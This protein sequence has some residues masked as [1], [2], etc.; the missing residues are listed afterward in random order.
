MKKAFFFALFIATASAIAT[1]LGC[2]QLNP[3]TENPREIVITPASGTMLAYTTQEFEARAYDKGGNEIFFTPSTW[4]VY[5]SSQWGVVAGNGRSSGGRPLAILTPMASG[6]GE[7][8]CFFND[9]Q[10]VATITAFAT[11]ESLSITP[12]R[13]SI[14]VYAEQEFTATAKDPNGNI[15]NL[16]V[17]TWEVTGGIGTI[18]PSTGSNQALFSATVAGVGTIDAYYQGKSAS[19]EVTVN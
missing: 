14:E 1:I 19:A 3:V 10:G 5:P 18:P 4:A 13:I 2:G 6:T 17:P 11:I 8:R 15:I 9:I 7:V 12:K 16:I